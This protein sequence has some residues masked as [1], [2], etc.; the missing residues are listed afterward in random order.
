LCEVRF[1]GNQ[2]ISPL[3]DSLRRVVRRFDNDKLKSN[4]GSSNIPEKRTRRFKLL[5]DRLALLWLF[6]FAGEEERLSQD[7]CDN[8]PDSETDLDSDLFGH[9]E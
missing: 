8:G 5:I 2:V 3:N 7:S 4:V 9:L 1:L 6:V